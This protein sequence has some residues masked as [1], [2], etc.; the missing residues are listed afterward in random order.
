VIGAG[1]VSLLAIAASPVKVADDGCP[2]AAQVEAALTSMLSVSDA[3]PTRTDVATL[4]HAQGALR[5]RLSDPDGAVIAERTLDG[6][7]SCAELGRMAAIVIASWESDVHPEFARQPTEIARAERSPIPEPELSAPVP[8]A[9]LRAAAYDIAAG[10]TL[11]QADTLAAGAT[12]GGAWFPR[13]VG[14][15][16]WVLG[17]GD[18][19]RTIAVGGHEAR[20][21][22]WTASLELAR[23]WDRDGFVLDAHGGPTLGWVATEGVD[24]AQ[25]LSDSALV[26]GGTAGLR[27][28]RW[29]SRHVAFWLDL[30]GFYFPRADSIYG[31]TA[32]APAAEAALPSWGGVV[33][34]GVAL[35]R[36][37]ISR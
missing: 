11:G 2:S 28:A 1:V 16:V 15:G 20:W 34:A 3:A 13:G 22:R 18:L 21:Q 33:S 14:L 5:I 12:I 8:V 9:T 32:G 23:R 31:T 25:N 26:V 24:Y 29:L 36:G 17:A 7:A 27:T 19:A 37:P 30:R 4:E 10:V 35:G 6:G